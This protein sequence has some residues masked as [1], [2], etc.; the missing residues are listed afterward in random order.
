[1]ILSASHISKSFGGIDVIKDASILINEREKAAIVGNN[2]AGKTTLLDMLTGT[3]EPDTGII[4]VSSGTSIGY[5]RQIN[6]IDSDDTVL[7]EM[8]Q[9]V[10]YLTEL[11]TRLLKVQEEMKNASGE[12]LELLYDTFEKL[13][14]RYERADGY[15]AKSRVTGILKGLGFAEE[16]FGKP[17]RHLSGGEKTRLFLGKLLIEHPDIIFL[18]E[19]TNHLDLSSIEWL[20]GFLLNYKGTVIVV[21]HDRYFLDRIVGK[22]IDIDQGHVETYTGNYSEFAQKKAMLYEARIKAYNKENII[23]DK[24]LK[25]IINKALRQI[26]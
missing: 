22:V 17:C 5:L 20:E 19:P 8:N 4:T 3:T 10:A 25:G 11:E 9:S 24:K 12:E 14:D 15:S 16:E 23:E 13:T 1:M 6:E 2:G 26:Q 7:S 18:D 21:S